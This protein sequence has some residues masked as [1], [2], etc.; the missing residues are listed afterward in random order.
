MKAASFVLVAAASWA[1]EPVHVPRFALDA[2]SHLTMRGAAKPLFV[3][4]PGLGAPTTSP[5][6]RLTNQVDP[7]QLHA[8]GGQLVVAALWPPFNVRPGRTAFDEALHQVDLLDDFVARHPEFATVRDSAAV[9]AV[10]AQHR[11]AVLAQVEGA[12]GLTRVDDVDRWY[13][14]GVRCVTLVHFVSSGVGG[15]AAG[16]VQ[17]LLFGASPQGVTA[18]GLSEFGRAVVNRMLDLGIIIDLAHASDA[19]ARDVLDLT[20]ARGVPVIVS[21]TGARALLPLER[22]VSDA[23]AQRIA[24]HG[25]LIGVNLNTGQTSTPP[26]FETPNHHRGTC[27]DVAAHWVHLASVVPATSLML[28]SDSNGLIGRAG[29][30]GACPGG[31]ANTATWPQLWAALVARGVPREALDGMGDAFVELWRRVERGA[32]PRAQAHARARLREAPPSLFDVGR[33]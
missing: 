17:R 13:A 9:A 11:L 26:E 15:A 18:E 25:G 27:D 2:H 1:S 33:W 4:E 16:Q 30:G 24:A 8:A 23:L 32:D 14:A 10:L 31:L 19:T 21:H 28:G 29:P 7:V 6:A 12:E 3:G 22:N 20:E 5:S